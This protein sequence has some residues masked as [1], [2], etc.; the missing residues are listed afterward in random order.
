MLEL[1]SLV[2]NASHVSNSTLRTEDEMGGSGGDRWSSSDI[3]GLEQ[4]AKQKLAEA[5]SDGNPNV[6]IS[7]AHEDMDEVNLLRGQAKNENTNLEFSDHSVKEPFDSANAEYIKGRIRE[8]IDRTSVTVVYLSANSAS[9]PWVNW[10]IEESFKRGKG[11]VGVYKGDVPP[12]KV[13]PAFAQNGCKA[14]KWQHDA[15]SDAIQE[16]R[17]NR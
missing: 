16:A 14:V 1:K 7:F 15:L 6:F 17:L 11:V 4:K 5:Q 10:E 8:H 3:S 13:P 2:V 12:R 9:S